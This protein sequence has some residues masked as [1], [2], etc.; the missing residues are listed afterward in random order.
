MV[1]NSKDDVVIVKV[2][3]SRMVKRTN[4][5]S[6]TD[7]QSQPRRKRKLVESLPSTDDV[8][9]IESDTQQTSSSGSNTRT[10]KCDSEAK[11]SNVGVG[12]NDNQLSTVQKT[13]IP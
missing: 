10:R 11:I 3:N 7:S 5:T 9:L 1:S 4:S 2:E 12:K 6:N 13:Y 8:L